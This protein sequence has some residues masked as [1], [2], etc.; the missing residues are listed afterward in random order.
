M[1]SGAP[2][3]VPKGVPGPMRSTTRMN[4]GGQVD[5]CKMLLAKTLSTESAPISVSHGGNL[6]AGRRRAFSAL[7]EHGA[8]GWCRL[9]PPAAQQC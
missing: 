6:P 5:V 2:L 1:P 8:Q 4:T 9:Q 7:Q 3:R